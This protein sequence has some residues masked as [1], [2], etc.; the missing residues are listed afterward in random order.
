M[1]TPFHVNQIYYLPS[2]LPLLDP[3]FTP[4]DNTANENRE[5]AEY[6][7]FEKEYNAGKIVEGALTGYLSWKFAY[8][9]R[10][11]GSR[12]LQFVAENPGYDVYFINPFPMQVKFF[13]N[14]WLQGE[15]CHPGILEL[16]Q[17]I[18]ERA[19][20]AIELAAEVQTK[21][22]ALYCNYWVGTH[23][24][25]NTYMAFLNPIIEVLRYRLS[26]SEKQKLHSIAD[27]G[28]NF[29]YIAF[30]IERAFSTL[31]YHNKS[32]RYLAYPYSYSDIRQRKFG[33]AGALLYKAFPDNS[34]LLNFAYT[35][36]RQ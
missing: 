29:S 15:F 23:G 9:T 8:K 33:H 36:V 28:N 3:A 12:F 16:S 19:G 25:W 14:L 4:Y 5:F 22:T 21:K 11:A 27:H 24:F 20:Y 18:F 13:K 2:Q 17:R 30:I 6:H 31:I 26:E 1:N 34:R 7:I 32:I 10:V 35:A